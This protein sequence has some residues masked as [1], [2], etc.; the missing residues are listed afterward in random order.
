VCS[1]EY[2]KNGPKSK[3]VCTKEESWGMGMSILLLYEQNKSCSDLELTVSAFSV[4][5]G[6]GLRSSYR[7]RI[8]CH[9]FVCVLD[10]Q[11][12]PGKEI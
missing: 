7:H 6:A 12:T 8:I 1:I 4:E 2:I 9:R 3:P 10:E 5:C 11:V